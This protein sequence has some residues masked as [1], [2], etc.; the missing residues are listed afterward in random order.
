M[1]VIPK[2][3]QLRENEKINKKEA[4]QFFLSVSRIA[5]AMRVHINYNIV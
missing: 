2:N 4:R 1:R 3:K 5:D